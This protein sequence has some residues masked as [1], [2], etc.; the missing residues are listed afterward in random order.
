MSELISSSRTCWL[1]SMSSE[2]PPLRVTG[3]VLRGAAM[4]ICLCGVGTLF[5]AVGDV[6]MGPE[7]QKQVNKGANTNG[8]VIVLLLCQP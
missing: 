8:S 4:L 7:R 1:S 3:V 2:S 6:L 5:S